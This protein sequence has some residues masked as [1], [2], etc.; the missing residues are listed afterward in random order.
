MGFIK[1]EVE[2]LRA[3]MLA[4]AFI[5][6]VGQ[7]QPCGAALS[8]VRWQ[9]QVQTS[10]ELWAGPM[11][12]Q[13]EDMIIEELGKHEYARIVCQYDHASLSV[14]SSVLVQ[15]HRVWAQCEYDVPS[16]LRFIRDAM[17]MDCK[18]D[19]YV[20]RCLCGIAVL[21]GV[22]P[23]DRQIALEICVEYARATKFPSQA[24][25]LRALAEERC[26][27]HRQS[28]DLLKR[29]KKLWNAESHKDLHANPPLDVVSGVG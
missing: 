1:V 29:A 27:H 18:G 8:S 14:K 16:G 19:E 11:S 21:K 24:A 17:K 4:A 7:V 22:F 20:T 15:Y 5:Y 12:G 10:D 25:S 26:G 6:Q 28:A 2:T 3:T 13:V 9:P 23:H